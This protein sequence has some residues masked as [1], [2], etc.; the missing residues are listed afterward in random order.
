MEVENFSAGYF[1]IEL[2]ISEYQDGPA[3]EAETHAFINRQFYSHSDGDPVFRLGL[4]GNPYFEVSAEVSIPADVI[5]IPREWFA[6]NRIE[7]GSYQ[8]VFILKPGHADILREAT[9]LSKRFEE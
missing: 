8:N 1:K 7:E 6:D 5:G 2:R 9:E 3:M 4:D